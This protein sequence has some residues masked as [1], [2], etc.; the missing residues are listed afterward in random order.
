MRSIRFGFS[1]GSAALATIS[2]LIDVGHQDLLPAADRAA[3]AA[4]PRLDPLD[5]PFLGSVVLD[6]AKQHAVAGGHDVPLIGGERLQQPPRGALI[7]AAV[8]VLDHAGQ[9]ENGQHAAATAD[10]SSTSR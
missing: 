5:D 4:V 3:D 10:A 9:P 6:G 7:D 1:R 8:V 2:Q